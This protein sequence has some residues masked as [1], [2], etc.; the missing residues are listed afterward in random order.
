LSGGRRPWLHL[1][2]AA[3]GASAAASSGLLV[4][5]RPDDGFRVPRVAMGLCGP[6]APR[7]NGLCSRVRVRVPIAM[8][9][10]E[11]RAT[12]DLTRRRRDYSSRVK[13]F[14]WL[15]SYKDASCLALP[16]PALHLWCTAHRGCC[17][18][19]HFQDHQATALSVFLHRNAGTH[20]WSPCALSGAPLASSL[21]KE[22]DLSRGEGCRN[23]KRPT[24][25]AHAAN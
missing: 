6:L 19:A 7:V 20:L 17:R 3:P 14:Y 25:P 23:A 21:Q 15:V 18:K 10:A 5:G 1:R 16:C 11:R 4:A 12:S 24:R 9:V 13:L 2:E 8:D 22:F